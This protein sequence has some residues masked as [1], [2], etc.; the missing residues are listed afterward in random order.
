MTPDFCALKYL[1]VLINQL[2]NMLLFAESDEKK[3]ITKI[4][5]KHNRKI[6]RRGLRFDFSVFESAATVE[7]KT[8]CNLKELMCSKVINQKVF[9]LDI[10]F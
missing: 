3:T 4:K 6:C 2:I 5:P 10:N 9:I 7:S 8:T 1:I